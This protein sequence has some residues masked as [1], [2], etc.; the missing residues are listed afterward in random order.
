LTTPEGGT[1]EWKSYALRA[2]QRRTLAADALIASSYLTGT[3][4]RRVRQ[5]LV[6]LFGGTV[7]KGTVSRKS[8]WDT[9]NSRSVAGEPI[10]R[11][12]LDGSSG[13][14]RPQADQL[15]D[16]TT[17]CAGR[18]SGRPEGSA[19]DRELGRRKRRGMAHGAGRSRRAGAML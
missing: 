3:N 17:R 1:A 13:A 12:I 11:L 19:R 18:A 9:W 6:A 2:Y 7:S 8:D 4:T 5:A 10:V 14:P 16:F 15:T